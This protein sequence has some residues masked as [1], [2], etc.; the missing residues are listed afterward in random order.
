MNE[1]VYFS[2]SNGIIDVTDKG[3]GVRQSFQW[4]K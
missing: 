2:L 1:W 4:C 3:V